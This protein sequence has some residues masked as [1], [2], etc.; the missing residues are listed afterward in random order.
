MQLPL[1]RTERKGQSRF[2]ME[3]S[4][5]CI[6]GVGDKA[7]LHMAAMIRLTYFSSR[8]GRVRLAGKGGEIYWKRMERSG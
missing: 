4:N 2:R 1:D 5:Y 8:V 3:K 7:D 6:S